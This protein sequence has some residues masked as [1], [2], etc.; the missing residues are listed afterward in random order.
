MIPRV[1]LFGYLWFAI[2]TIHCWGLVMYSVNWFGIFGFGNLTKKWVEYK[3][4]KADF[5]SFF[6]RFL[7]SFQSSESDSRFEKSSK[8]VKIWEGKL[9][10]TFT[11]FP[12]FLNGGAILPKTEEPKSVNQIHHYFWSLCLVWNILVDWCH[13]FLTCDLSKSSFGMIWI[14]IFYNRM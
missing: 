8:I 9:K 13:V 14:D 11:N 5:S 2:S 12:F 7:T 3:V 4:C 1:F 6:S 10:K